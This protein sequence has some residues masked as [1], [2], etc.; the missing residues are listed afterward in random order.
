MEMRIVCI[1]CI[2]RIASWMGEEDSVVLTDLWT[3]GANDFHSNRSNEHTLAHARSRNSANVILLL[4]V[5]SV[6]SL[7]HSSLWFFSTT[8]RRYASTSKWAERKGR[9][10]ASSE[11]FR[12][13]ECCVDIISPLSRYCILRH[14]ERWWYDDTLRGNAFNSRFY[15][16]PVSSLQSPVSIYFIIPLSTYYIYPTS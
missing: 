1:V 15:G 3:W 13:Y 6:M 5:H 2:V 9:N 7:K 11:T 10:L 16:S 4:P 14:E 12:M 8:E